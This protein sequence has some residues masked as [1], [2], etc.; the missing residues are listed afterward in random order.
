MKE[1]AI[2]SELLCAKL[3]FH[4]CL[5]IWIVSTL[6]DKGKKKCPNRYWWGH[7]ITAQIIIWRK[8]ATEGNLEMFQFFRKMQ[9]L[10]LF[11]RMAVQ[12]RKEPLH[13]DNWS[14]LSSVSED[15]KLPPL[16]TDCTLQTKCPDVLF[17][18]FWITVTEYYPEGEKKILIILMQLGGCLA[19]KNII[20]IRNIYHNCME[21]ERNVCLSD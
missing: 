10:F 1:T 4:G 17:D 5:S 21:H 20:C 11:S 2:S 9:K 15:E 13:T 18:T 3:P 14:K 8:T 19:L 7:D 12:V 6:A 16:S